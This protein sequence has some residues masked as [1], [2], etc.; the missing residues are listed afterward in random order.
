[1]HSTPIAG[2]RVGVY[3]SAGAVTVRGVAVQVAEEHPL[4]GGREG[5]D[6]HE[7]CGEREAHSVHPAKLV[8]IGF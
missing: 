8:N 2:V 4:L 1:M 7:E 5:R 6:D 3:R